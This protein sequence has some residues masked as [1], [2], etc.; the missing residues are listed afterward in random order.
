MIPGI[1]GTV[2]PIFKSKNYKVIRRI[3][4]YSYTFWPDFLQPS[5]KAIHVIEE[6]SDDVVSSGIN[7]GF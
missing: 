4:G 5:Q 2:I 6:L 3:P 1:T 7:F